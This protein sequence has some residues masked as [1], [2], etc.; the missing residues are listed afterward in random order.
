M[1][2]S[3]LVKLLVVDLNS[4]PL[5]DTHTHL[6]A[7]RLGAR[8]L[9]DILLYHMVISDLYAAGCPSGA[10]L[11]EFP[12]WPTQTEARARLRE[13]VPYLKYIQNTSGFW[14]VRTILRDLYGWTNPITPDNWQKLDDLIRERADDRRWHRDI[15]RRSGVVKTTTELSRRAGGVDDDIFHYSMEWA[16]FARTQRGEYDTALYELER[17]WGLEPATPI[18]HGA[19]GRPATAQTIRTLDD[20]RSALAH[21]VG[22]LAVAPVLSMATHI[23][24]DIVFRPVTD[25]E[26]SAAMARRSEAG[27]AERDIYA[28]YIHEAFL[29]ALAPHADRIVF[30]CSFAAEPMPHETASLV[31][32]RAIAHLADIAARHPK[33]KFLCFVSS[34]HANQSLCTLCRELPNFALAGYW[35]HNFFPGAIRQVMEERLDMLP[36]NKQVGFFS[37]AYCIEW[38]YAKAEIVRRQM[39]QV[40]AQK[41]AQGQYTKAEALAIARAILFETAQTLLGMK[42]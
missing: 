39:A 41:I 32:Q 12:G 31:P 22:R 16:F 1:N 9:H 30:Q 42:P 2:Y 28:S 5:L 23:S 33:V 18:P 37:D 29:S 34:R 7:G 35:W 10:R 19:G 8:G 4:V 20:V 17:C 24:T 25:S 6:T 26:M 15:L 21:Y 14:G 27:A 38:T 11:T 3:E 13:A 36:T 40:L